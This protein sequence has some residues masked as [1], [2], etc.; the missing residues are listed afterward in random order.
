MK[1]IF[2]GILRLIIGID[3]H[4]IKRYLGIETPL[5]KAWWAC[6]S[7]HI[8]KKLDKEHNTNYYAKYSL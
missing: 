3:R 8:Q 2:K 4:I 7:Q 1:H 6:Y 5:Y